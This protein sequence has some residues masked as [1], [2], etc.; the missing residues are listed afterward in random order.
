MIYVLGICVLYDICMDICMIDD[1]CMY[2]GGV[3]G[4][5]EWCIG[6]GVEG[7][8][9]DSVCGGMPA[10]KHIMCTKTH[11]LQTQLHTHTHVLHQPTVVIDN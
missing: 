9:L 6:G 8:V 7:G 11:P 5:T 3:G 10:T 4:C 2:V 1:I